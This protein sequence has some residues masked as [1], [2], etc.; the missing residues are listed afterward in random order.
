MTHEQKINALET[1]LQPVI[2]NGF[3][4]IADMLAAAFDTAM[5][6][7]RER[8][9]NADAYERTQDR[10]GYANGFKPRG[11]KTRV[12]ELK[13]NV[14]QVRDVEPFKPSVLERGQRS[15]RAL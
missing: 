2:E 9:L 12:G 6:I 3:E 11:L 13:L 7:E 15:E 10:K 14:P 4:G 8:Y 1:V 5:I